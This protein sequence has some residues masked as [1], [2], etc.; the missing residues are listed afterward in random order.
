MV[1]DEQGPPQELPES[2]GARECFASAG[3]IMSPSQTVK[4][5]HKFSV[6]SGEQL[7]VFAG[8]S[9]TVND[10]KNQRPRR[11]SNLH[12]NKI[13]EEQVS[14]QDFCNKKHPDLSEVRF[15][16]ELSQDGSTFSIKECQIVCLDFQ[17]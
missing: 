17:V 7:R 11:T 6:C 12:V 3:N 5:N 1:H 10:L 9:K 15:Q 2:P 16:K 4:S 8:T 14:P 13:M